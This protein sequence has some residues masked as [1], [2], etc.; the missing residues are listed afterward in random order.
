MV[1]SNAFR[2]TVRYAKIMQYTYT[3]ISTKNKQ[4]F[5]LSD[6]AERLYKSMGSERLSKQQHQPNR[7]N[8][9][10]TKGNITNN[11]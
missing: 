1:G 3:G 6:E 8:T 2:D 10:H 9:P 4:V 5:D 11:N 7:S